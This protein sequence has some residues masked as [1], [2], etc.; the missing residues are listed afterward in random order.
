MPD[1]ERRRASDMQMA[2]MAQQI[3]D[4]KELLESI[5][6]QTK[7]TNGRVTSLELSD[8]VQENRI[9][10]AE[11]LL[12]KLV[13]DT[14]TLQ[15]WRDRMAGALAVLTTLLVPVCLYVI[16]LWLEGKF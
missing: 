12:A 15:T 1:E 13:C 8:V 14:D 4:Q 11:V 10:G 2:T 16:Y 3:T 6:A 7:K 5:Y 9:K